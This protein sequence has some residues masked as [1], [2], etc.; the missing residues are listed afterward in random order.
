MLVS[1]FGKYL[2]FYV[3][4]E[5]TQQQ[6][7]SDKPNAF[8]VLMASQ[9][10]Q[11]TQTLP[12]SFAQP[13]NKKEELHNSLINFLRTESLSWTP[14]EVACGVADNAVKTLTDVLWY[15]NGQH[16]KLS[17]RSCVV[18]VVF[19]QFT[20][21]NK[22]EKSKHRKREIVSLSADV[23]ASHCQRIFS[24]LQSAFW[25]R[26]GWRSFKK[27]VEL[28]ARGLQK[29]CDLLSCKRQRMLE[30]H[31]SEE[32]VR[33]VANSMAVTFIAARHKSSINLQELST[34]VETAGIDEVISLQDAG[35]LPSDRRRRYDYIEE[36]KQG[37]KMPIVLVTYS[38]NLGNLHWVW[39]TTANSINSALQ[40]CQ[41]LIENIQVQIPQFHTRAMLQAA[42]EKYG[43]ISPSVKKSVL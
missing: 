21:Y 19:S 15:I 29:Y 42:F 12:S 16:S 30:L 24:N 11:S 33:T 26:P 27:E 10:R 39:H 23:L 35:V 28:L 2:K 4:K 8:Q 3:K 20:E 43:L 31:H 7:S 37:L 25:D 22:P 41:P 13:R 40:T 32:Q 17:E 1:S 6:T 36:L 34:T 14:S 38:S 9:A 18:P 5:S